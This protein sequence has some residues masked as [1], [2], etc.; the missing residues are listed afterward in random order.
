MGYET[1]ES[2]ANL[3]RAGECSH[4]PALFRFYKELKITDE[5][6]MLIMHVQAFQQAGNPFP[7]P[8]E[9]GSRMMTTQKA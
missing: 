5:E 2:I 3:D 1:A 8:D 9:I 6:A 7:T 4:F